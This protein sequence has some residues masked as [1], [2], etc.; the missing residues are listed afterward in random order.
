ML[1]LQSLAQLENV[2]GQAAGRIIADNCNSKVV[3]AGLDFKSADY[4]SKTLGKTTISEIAK[5]KS[6]QAGMFGFGKEQISEQTV[7]TARDL[8]TPDEVRRLGD[9][10][11]IVVIANKLPIRSRRYWFTQD[12]KSTKVNQLGQVLTIK[13]EPPEKGDD[14]RNK[15]RGFNSFNNPSNSNNRNN[16]SNNSNNSNNRGSANGNQLTNNYQPNLS[17]QNN[18]S[19]PSNQ[20]SHPPKATI[21]YR[22]KSLEQFS[23]EENIR[24]KNKY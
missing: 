6:K 7:K 2:Y 13:I 11:Q 14:N 3:L 9:F 1:G 17:K 20:S 5:S 8:M 12:G 19:N 16:N 21:E 4:L 23:G 15:P 10:E 24:E 18:R 22:P